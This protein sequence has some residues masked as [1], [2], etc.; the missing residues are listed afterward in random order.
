MWT[1]LLLF[2]T[3]YT[4]MHAVFYY[5]VHVLFGE[6]KGMALA[7]T[8][9]LGLMI[10]SPVLC[11]LLERTGWETQARVLAH[12]GYPWM[13]FLFLA[14]WCSVLVGAVNA[15]LWGLHRYAGLNMVRIPEKP[16][17]VAVLVAA[18][19]LTL[20]GAFEAWNIRVER[21]RLETEKLPPHVPRLVV[22]Q[23]SDV[24]LG[25]N[26]RE[27]R[28]ERILRAVRAAEPDLLVSTGDLVDGAPHSLE[29]LLPLF[30]SVQPKLGKVAVVGNHEYYVGLQ[31]AM[32]W[33]RRA[34]FML[35]KDN[36]TTLA[37]I[38][39]VAGVDDT[40]KDRPDIESGLLRSLPDELFTLYLK[41][42]P[43]VCPETVGLFDLQ[44]S[45]HTHRG[46]IFPFSL[47]VALMY[48]FFN[49]T[50]D[51]GE[52][53]V[54]HTSRGTGTWGPP[55]RLLAPPEI[56]VFEIVRKH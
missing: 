43:Q 11:R 35:L 29:P 9:F 1:F 45:G 14:F 23:I 22:A 42:R 18:G 21:I 2:L 4:S 50:Y 17:A 41:H 10:L 3:V 6:R 8:V 54:L 20:Y 16:A 15:V 44:L 13:G 26:G 40:W 38:L 31:G 24:H 55:I 28:A 39:N 32:D 12:V 51:M 25:L 46:Q 27:G 47:F 30:Q 36:G 34:G 7:F 5:R 53:S 49:G 56:T 19:I 37:G 48:P 52:G 33:T